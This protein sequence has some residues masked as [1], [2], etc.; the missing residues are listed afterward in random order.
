MERRTLV[1]DAN[2]LIRAVFGHRVRH[3]HEVHADRV[4][5]FVPVTAYAE[6]EEHLAAF[7]MKRGGKPAKA[8]VS[9]RAMAALT[10]LVSDDLYGNF[11]AE[12]R[13]RLG[14]RPGGLAG[15]CGRPGSWLSDL[16]GRHRLFRMWRGHLDVRQYRDPSCTAAV[17]RDSSL[18]EHHLRPGHSTRFANIECPTSSTTGGPSA[19]F[20]SSKGAWWLPNRA[21][22]GG[23]PEPEAARQLVL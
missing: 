20:R 13:K 15:A 2:I 1:L 14:A 4:S 3:H 7:V 8:L 23:H 6:A 21:R 10:T 19:R 11:E 9:L 16:D 18:P 17:F 22:C 12:A 5:F